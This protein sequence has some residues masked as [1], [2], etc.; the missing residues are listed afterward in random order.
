MNWLKNKMVNAVFYVLAIYWMSR[1]K[2][3]ENGKI[4]L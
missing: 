1:M 4:T 3:D 2:V